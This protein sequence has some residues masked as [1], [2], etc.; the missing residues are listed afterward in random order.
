MN[1][2]CLIYQ[3]AGIGD[4]LYCQAIAKHYVNA[5]YHVIYP[6]KSN[7][8]YLKD[9][10]KYEGISFVDEESDFPYKESYNQGND[11]NFDGDFIYLNLDQSQRRVGARN[12][13]MLSKYELVGLDHK[14]WVDALSIER[15]QEREDWLYYDYLKLVDGEKY[16]LTNTKYGTPPHYKDLETPKLSGDD[17]IVEMVFIDGTNIMDWIKVIENASGIV[18]VDT[19][20]QYIME[21]LEL[22]YDFYHCY[23]RD[24]GHGHHINIIKNLFT[25]PWD[26]KKL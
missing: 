19:C 18:T 24:G 15:N 20:I 14:T 12:G 10:L 25:I 26:Y 11:T 16:I 7:I 9:Y 22:N 23:P 17:K 4:I 5:G 1:K 8:M 13:Y 3:P 2:T 21:K 6:L